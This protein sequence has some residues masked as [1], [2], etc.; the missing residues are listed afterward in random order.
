MIEAIFVTWDSA[1][2]EGVARGID[3]R[4]Y[5]LLYSNGQSLAMSGD[6]SLPTLTGRHEQVAGGKLKVPM[7]G[8][9][10]LIQVSIAGGRHIWTYMRLYLDIVERRNG[11]QFVGAERVA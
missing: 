6:D 4:D 2:S 10:I 11:T 8:D 5:R 3:G 9:P 7:V 1:H